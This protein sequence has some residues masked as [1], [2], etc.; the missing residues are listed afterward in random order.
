MLPAAAFWDCAAAWRTF[1]PTRLI[2]YPSKWLLNPHASFANTPHQTVHPFRACLALS[3]R[4]LSCSSIPCCAQQQSMAQAR[5]RPSRP[6]PP[7]RRAA[8]P[9]ATRERQAGGVMLLL[10]LCGLAR[11]ASGFIVVRPAATDML[12]RRCVGAFVGG[13]Q[14]IYRSRIDVISPH[15]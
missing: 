9:V 5:P 7:Q 11:R 1:M 3:A 2:Q 12:C 15:I 14:S 8:A 10:S 13:T 4:I 6:T